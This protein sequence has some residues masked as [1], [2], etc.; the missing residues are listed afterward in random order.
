MKHTIKK[1][2]KTSF[3]IIS[4]LVIGLAI[5]YSRVVEYV[6]MIIASFFIINIVL[7]LRRYIKYKLS[8]VDTMTRLEFETCSNYLILLQE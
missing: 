5:N 4:I 3:I 1:L 6:L 8:H 7:K 2:D